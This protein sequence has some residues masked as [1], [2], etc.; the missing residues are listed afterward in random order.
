M[1]GTQMVTKGLDFDY[2][3]LVGIISADHLLHYPDFR[4]SER[5]FQ[6]MEQVS[7]RAGRKHN[8]GR[9]VIQAFE[10][11]HPVIQDVLLHD[12][13]RFYT[14]EINERREFGFPPFSRM[15]EITVKHGDAVKAEAA[16]KFLYQFLFDRLGDR[17][18][19]PIVPS[20]PRVRNRYIQHIVL[21]LEKKVKLIRDAKCWIQESITYLKKQKGMTTIRI[22]VNVDP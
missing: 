8:R 10:I 7:G 6:L 9:V 1:I 20:I 11:K 5:A 16:A 17:V 4:S 19:G 14:R 13:R 2:V 22:S 12:Y 15:I 3:S 21:K 18:K